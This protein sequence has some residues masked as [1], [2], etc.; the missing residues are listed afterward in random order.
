MDL[1]GKPANEAALLDIRGLKTHFVTDDGLVQAVD[2]VEVEVALLEGRLEQELVAD[3]DLGDLVGVVVSADVC[4][5]PHL[6]TRLTESMSPLKLYEYLSGGRP[7]VA[8][9]LPGIRGVHPTV[10]LASDRELSQPKRCAVSLL[11]G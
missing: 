7:V 8:S 1:D 10:R 5:I 11:I 3:A 2:G 6:R 9:D 4:I